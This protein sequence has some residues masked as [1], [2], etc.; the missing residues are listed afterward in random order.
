[1]DVKDIKIEIRKHH[2]TP[3]INVLDLVVDVDGERIVK[4]TQ[5]KDTDKAWQ[6]FVEEAVRIAKDLSNARIE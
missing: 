2:I 4:Q 5:H 6:T 1:M 3:G